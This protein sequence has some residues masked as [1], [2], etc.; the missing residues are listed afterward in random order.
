MPFFAD[1]CTQAGN[2][3]EGIRTLQNLVKKNPDFI[4]G[5][6]QLATLLIETGQLKQALGTMKE[7][8]TLHPRYQDWPPSVYTTTQK[9]PN[10]RLL[11]PTSLST[12]KHDLRSNPS[13]DIPVFTDSQFSIT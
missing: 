6:L 2:Y 11:S 7:F 1:D 4:A 10:P 12:I 13:K 3:E 5:W 9:C 8:T